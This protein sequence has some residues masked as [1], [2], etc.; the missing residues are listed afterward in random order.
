MSRSLPAAP[1][2][3]RT[4]RLLL[5][6]ARLRAAGR[7]VRQQQLLQNRKGSGARPALSAL[8]VLSAIF[9]ATLI[10]G[11]AVYLV[12]E[13]ARACQRF[14]ATAQGK[15]VVSRRLLDQVEAWEGGAAR[16]QD[17][18]RYLVTR[19]AERSVREYGGREKEAS[20]SLWREIMTNRSARL[21]SESEAA[22]GVDALSGWVGLP[23]MFGSLVLICWLV[24]MVCQGEGMEL[25]FQR[26]RHPMWEWLLSHPV[27]PGAVFL[28]EMLAPLSV[29]PLYWTGPVYVG[30]LY[31]LVYGLDMGV[32]AA[33]LGGPP[34]VTGAA[35]LGKAL[36]IGVM[37]RFPPR[38]RG[39]ILGI[40]SWLG[41]SFL[42]FAFMGSYVLPR[43]VMATGN[44]W[45][46]PASY[47]WPWLSVLLGGGSGGGYSFLRG[48][49]AC[50]GL[51]AIMTAAGVKFS[52][53]GARRGL[54]GSSKSGNSVGRST[55]S[56]ALGR[57]PLLRK[58]CL[59]FVRDR[60]A[61]VQAIL[62]PITAAGFQLFNFRGFL[63]RAQGE[64][65]YLCSAAICFGTYFLWVLGPRSL[66]SEGNALWIPL[67]W[68]MGLEALLKAKARLW[69][70]I[71]SVIV[72]PIMLYAAAL[73]PV[74][75]WKVALVLVGWVLFA[76]SMAEKS[77]TLVTVA[78]SSGEIEKIPT[79]RRMATQMGMWTFSIGVITEQW[80]LAIVGI[81][82]S[83]ITAAAMW[84]D[85]RERLPYLYDP[86]SE[87]LPQPPTLMHAVVAISVMVEITSV[88]TA[89]IAIFAGKEH[90]GTAMLFGYGL[91]SVCV[92]LYTMT[93]LNSR[94]VPSS[95]VW[96]WQPEC[97]STN[98]SA[99]S[100][101]ISPR[102]S[103]HQ[104]GHRE[105]SPSRRRRLLTEIEAIA[106]W[107]GA[108]VLAG[109]LLG[110]LAHGYGILL[111]H[112]P[113]IRDVIRQAEEKR[114][115]QPDVLFA[116]GILAVCFAPLAEEY[117]FRGLLYRALDR[118][119]G[120]WKAVLGSAAFFTIYHPPLAWIPV[121]TVGVVNALLFKN[122][123]K[124]MPAVA[125][126]MAYNFVVSVLSG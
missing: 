91:S 47:P 30:S 113:W 5:R 81:V 95:R 34:V 88:L 78:S 121:F 7:Q 39:A 110:V 40:T 106:P 35:C 58:E 101:S 83:H 125:L 43:F 89:L 99:G 100:A 82:F 3:W 97:A 13:A 73:F 14:E 62:I 66:T 63:E 19:E 96:H 37:V 31:G 107:L 10:H 32:L 102:V 27:P 54:S 8:A 79:G 115:S 17:S 29:N 75:I 108:A 98:G 86:W 38:S 50:W 23:Q 61:I 69:A 87:Q 103:L 116:Y 104:D 117:L 85:F 4:V 16:S 55:W 42:M 20:E 68:P 53:W 28:A 123:G 126:H 72:S 93:F 41:Y 6:A 24:M 70:F 122:S 15:V 74:E 9:V 59:W 18:L 2:F 57:R 112:L 46:V 94:G 92:C 33:L 12:Y 105:P 45:S 25:D 111:H 22:P 80:H 48:I 118:E 51:G 76:G 77:V 119:W 67:G 11:A 49:A 71:S 56:T 124:L 120:G 21:V 26:R 44:F 65:S 60:G 90:L 114:A 109:A 64:W 52:V 84:Q 1:G 36:E